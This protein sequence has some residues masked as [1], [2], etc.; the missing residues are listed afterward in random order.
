[1][2]IMVMFRAF[3]A[4][5]DIY[6]YEKFKEKFGK[7]QKRRWFNEGL[8]EIVNNRFVLFLGHVSKVSSSSW[9]Y[10][11]RQF[12]FQW[13]VANYDTLQ[14]KHLSVSCQNIMCDDN[15]SQWSLQLPTDDR[16]CGFVLVQ[17]VDWCVLLCDMLLIEMKLLRRDH[18][19]NCNSKYQEPVFVYLYMMHCIDYL[20]TFHF[21][22]CMCVCVCPCVWTI[23]LDRVRQFRPIADI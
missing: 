8:D 14:N 1:M 9:P 16:I 18:L 5:K 23:V 21:G 6:P 12:S 7:P 3:L 22:V 11:D 2:L 13:A 15:V 4:S 17:S 10:V 19:Q 20:I